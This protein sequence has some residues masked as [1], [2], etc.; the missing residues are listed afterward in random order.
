MNPIPTVA[1]FAKNP[2]PDPRTTIPPFDRIT[3]YG[4][5]AKSTTLVALVF[6]VFAT[7]TN[8]AEPAARPNILWITSEDNGQQLGC[9]GDTYADTPRLD[10]LAGRSL[11]YKTAWSNAPVCAPARTTIISGMYAC[12]LGAQHMRS[13]V[14]LPDGVT[15]Y[16]RLLRDAGYYC[17][18]NS[19]TDYNLVK[20][21]ELAGWNKSSG[22]A[23]W[24]NRPDDKT[25]FFAV[26]NFTT[27]HESKIRNKPHTLVHDPAKAPLPAYHPDLPEVRRD[28]AQ[29]YDRLTEMDAQVGKIL[30]QLQADGLADSTI[31]FYYGDHGSGMPRSKRTPLDSGLRVPMILHVPDSYKDL[32]PPEYAVGGVSERPVSFVDLV[33]TVLSIAGEPLPPHLQGTAFAGPDVA[34]EFPD[35]VYGFRGRM[36]ERIDMSRSCT[37]GRYV[38]VRHFM[39]ELPT[40][41]HVAYQFET[42]TTQAWYD[43]FVAGKLNEVQSAPWQPR[44]VEELF[45]LQS[46]PDETANVVDDPDYRMI[47]ES[48]RTATRQWMIRIGDIGIVPEAMM[49]QLADGQSPRALYEARPESWAYYVDTAWQAVENW[50]ACSRA[51]VAPLLGHVGDASPVIDYWVTRGLS[52]GLQS[53]ATVLEDDLVEKLRETLRDQLDELSPT[54]VRIVA[55]S[56]LFDEGTPDDRAAALEVLTELMD[57]DQSDYY[58]SLAALNALTS[59]IDELP[60]ATRREILQLQAVKPDSPKMNDLV[61]KLMG[62]FEESFGAVR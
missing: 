16:P 42:E 13:A 10:E 29:Y 2:S 27:S 55:A 38:Y 56:G 12:A 54:N 61:P 39:P 37:D 25:P 57:A 51:S 45:D 22:K 7:Q 28:W 20:G 52:L 58:T 47:A 62:Y 5:A 17:T 1:D 14:P 32:A 6:C 24:R 15:L 46:D 48:M 36:D 31:V 4:F 11:R 33:P 43:A 49:H 21:D 30:D 60:E 18:N 9:Y 44:P 34:R 8:A 53:H 59:I 19:K 23:H 50:R 35:Y 26:F 3:T 41:Q 40:L